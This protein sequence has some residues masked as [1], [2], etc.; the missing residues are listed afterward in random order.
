MIAAGNM[1]REL[2]FIVEFL[3]FL[4]IKTI[5]GGYIMISSKNNKFTE[6]CMQRVCCAERFYYEP[7]SYISVLLRFSL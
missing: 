5:K 4:I 1:H 2:L 7:S 6:F 3:V